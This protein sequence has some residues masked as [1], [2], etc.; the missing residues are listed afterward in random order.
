MSIAKNER[1][2]LGIPMGLSLLAIATAAAGTWS[3]LRHWRGLTELQLRLDRCV[4][5]VA[6]KLKSDA[7]TIRRDEHL[8]DIVREAVR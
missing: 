1:G 6:L 4:G 2:L 8:C 5:S 7:A 3:V